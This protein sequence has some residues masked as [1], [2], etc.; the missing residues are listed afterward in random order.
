MANWGRDLALGAEAG[1][2]IMAPILQAVMFKKQMERDEKNRGQNLALRMAELNAQRQKEYADRRAKAIEAALEFKGSRSKKRALYNELMAD[3]QNTLSNIDVTVKD[4]Q[5]TFK[6][7]ANDLFKASQNPLT[8]PLVKNLVSPRQ[9]K[10]G[11]GDQKPFQTFETPSFGTQ[12][13]RLDPLPV[14]DGLMTARATAYGN[15]ED[16]YGSITAMPNQ[17][18]ERQAI[19][20]STI[21]VDPNVIPYGSR[22]YVTSKD[23]A[24][25]EELRRLSPNGDSIFYAHDTGSAVKSRKA[26]NGTVPVIDFYTGGSGAE[27]NSFNA[28][29][30]NDIVYKV[31]PNEVA[32]TNVEP[33]NLGE[34]FDGQAQEENRIQAMEE[35]DFKTKQA[36]ALQDILRKQ[37]DYANA[38]N[39][40]RRKEAQADLDRERLEIDAGRLALDQAKAGARKAPQKPQDIFDILAEEDENQG[41]YNEVGLEE[42]NAL[43]VP[44]QAPN[45]YQGLDETKSQELRVAFE[46]EMDKKQMKDEERNSSAITGMQSIDRFIELNRENVTGG[47][48]GAA[49]TAFGLRSIVDKGYQEMQALSNALRLDASKA[50]KGAISDKE[51]IFLEKST[52]NVGNTAEANEKVGNLLRSA[53]QR[54]LD[55]SE[56]EQNY[57]AAHKTLRG[58]DQS[59]NE[60][61]R[62][63]PLVDVKTGQKNPNYLSYKEYFTLKNRG[64]VFKNAQDAIKA[65]VPIGSTVLIG[66]VLQIAE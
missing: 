14:D 16:Q 18:G 43:G 57:A 25:A 7:N 8:S 22:V 9:N 5:P 63:V 51:Q 38:P 31:L 41:M 29:I 23:P 50:L 64:H 53:F 56:F 40:E 62:T 3:A 37:F 60:Y 44:V 66:G 47:L 27:T 55:K 13:E 20:G 33:D 45:P 17:S 35:Q 48:E 2:A 46:K 24:K 1:S 39:E 21:A 61:I 32:K 54:T 11:T 15:D 12:E 4:G 59:W 10:V 49:K 42:S 30:G 6:G 26:S 65:K 52:L 28:R 36:L 58:S 19:A 34:V